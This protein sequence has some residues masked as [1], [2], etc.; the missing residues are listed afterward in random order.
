MSSFTRR[1]FLQT[2]SCVTLGSWLSSS[3]SFAA[4]H[5]VN[6]PH[7]MI[8]SGPKHH[9]FGY[10]D[11]LEFDPTGRYVLSNEVS[12][13][14]RTP[15]GSDR[16]GVG[17]VDLQNNDEWIELGST[18]AWGW[19]QGCMLQ[20][21]PGSK[22]K[23]LWNDREDGQFV[24]RIHDIKTG[25]TRTVPAPIYSLSPD[26]K[27][28]VTADFRR[29]Q[30]TRPGYGYVG[31]A[32]PHREELAPEES[33]IFHVDLETGETKL[34]VSLAD[35]VEISRDSKPVGDPKSKHWFNHLLFNTD[36]SRFIFLHRYTNP[37]RRGWQTRM[38]TADPDGKNVR[39]VDDNGLTSHFIWKDPNRILAWSRQPSDGA[40][41]YL[42]ED[43]AETNPQAVGKDVMTR[44]GHCTYLA[45]TEWIINDTYPDRDRNQTV[46]LYHPETKRKVVLGKFHSPKRYSGEWRCDTHPRHS[47]DGT[48]IVI[49]T[50]H[51]DLGR[52]LHLMDVSEIIG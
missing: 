7:R 2:A 22:T 34:I 32:D 47:P 14:G 49:D 9:W 48:K 38:L 39:I 24:C 37:G 46:Y 44:D 42:F 45:D 36:G 4:E 3:K 23:V 20:W 5:Q 50:P 6:V 10:Y 31:L 11:K 35:A 15:R 8:T 16:I 12:F 25:Q 30:E 27:S 28:A 29:I 18:S 33:G 13:E 43:A 21:V 41:F 51:G 17:M 1:T 40:A 52:Q 19:Q 26:G